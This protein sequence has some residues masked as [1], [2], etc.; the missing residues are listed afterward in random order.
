MTANPEKYRLERQ[1]PRWQKRRLEIM[2]RDNFQCSFCGDAK[3]SLNVHHKYYVSGRKPWQYPDWALTTLCQE[4][5]GLHHDSQVD[6]HFESENGVFPFTNWEHVIRNVS[7]CS[8]A[9]GFIGWLRYYLDANPQIS[10]SDLVE[11]LVDWMEEL[12][13]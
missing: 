9:G 12:K 4:C 1:D 7:T 10:S 13:K 11:A 8:S 6:E 2:Q 5:H 3:A